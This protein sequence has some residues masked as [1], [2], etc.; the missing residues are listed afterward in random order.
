MFN[1]YYVEGCDNRELYK[2]LIGVLLACCDSYSLIY[3]KYRECEKLS[4]STDTIKRALEKYKI[5]SRKTLQW[6]LTKTL[7]EQNHIYRMVVYKIVP[8]DFSV[9]SVL[10]SVNTLWDWGYPDYPMDLCFYRKG[11]VHFASCTHERM[12][13]L[14]LNADGDSLSTKDFESIGLKLRFLRH[15]DEGKMFHL[16]NTVCK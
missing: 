3:F 5:E 13:E 15:I 1:A 7:N 11:L 16:G 9:L 12:N 8:L 6:P 10:C 2:K 14:Y 4:K